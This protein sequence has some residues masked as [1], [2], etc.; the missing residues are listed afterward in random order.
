MNL[1]TMTCW[2]MSI[3]PEK[4]PDKAEYVTMTFEKGVPKTYERRRN[5]SF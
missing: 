4:A 3:T 2:Y 1:T 5:E